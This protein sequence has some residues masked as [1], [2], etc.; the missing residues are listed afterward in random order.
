MAS[1][2]EVN[3][4][5][6]EYNSTMAEIRSLKEEKDN[7]RFE[8]EKEQFHLEQ[9]PF[10]KHLSDSETRTRVLLTI[11]Y[12][13]VFVSI[14]SYGIVTF[15]SLN[16]SMQSVKDK[17]VNDDSMQAY[18]DNDAIA[19]LITVLLG[20]G[21]TFLLVRSIILLIPLLK[22]YISFRKTP[23]TEIG[24]GVTF[25]ED[26]KI[27][28]GKI[29]RYQSEIDDIDR[30]IINATLRLDKIK[31]RMTELDIPIPL[32]PYISKQPE[33]FRYTDYRDT[34][35]S[36]KGEYLTMEQLNTRIHE[37]TLEI[38]HLTKLIEA[39]RKEEY[40][41][42][43]D[44]D[45]ITNR[46]EN[47]KSIS[48]LAGVSIVGCAIMTMATSWIPYVGHIFSVIGIAVFAIYAYKYVKVYEKDFDKYFVEKEFNF[49]KS[50]AF[51]HD[52]H[53]L[54]ETKKSI[55][56]ERKRLE[57]DYHKVEERLDNWINEKE[58]RESE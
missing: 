58:N 39:K 18:S 30:L 57:D 20:I 53:P 22:Q 14:I 17:G 47:A 23:M 11:I 1:T 44:I 8:L 46:F 10:R 26:K 40:K 52:L 6:A 35:F 33:S 48:I 34:G 24:L 32:S 43:E 3:S 42:I 16:F 50:Y 45:D 7:Y 41:I 4:I 31:L 54:S 49:F 56:R 27:T 2:F 19:L 25:Y 15:R 28:E 51:S 29:R 13:S 21:L 55:T 9:L 36:T 5:N 12:S 38:E 37:D